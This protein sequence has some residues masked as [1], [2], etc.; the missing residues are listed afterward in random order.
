[1]RTELTYDHL[2]AVRSYLPELDRAL[3]PSNGRRRHW[4]QRELS[5]EQR[6]RMN[7]QAVAER[8]AKE[9]NLGLGLKALGNAPA[10]LDLSALDARDLIVTS[11]AELEEAVCDKLG[12]TP[13]ARPTTAERITRLIGLLDRIALHED[14]ADHVHAEA[15]RLRQ[16]ARIV[17]GE[18]EPVVRLTARCIHCR[19]LSLRA[20]PERAVIAARNAFAPLTN[21]E[22]FGVLASQVHY[23][24][25]AAT[26]TILGR[27]VHVIGANDAKAEPKV[28]G[29]TCAGA[30]VDEASTLPKDFFDQLN[31]RC[32]V[33]GAKIFA[34]TNPD[35]P[36]H[37]LRKEYLL[38]PS[39]TSLRA[40]HFRLDDNIHLDPTYVETIKS[41]YTGL[42]YKR[43]V[44]GLW[45]QAEGAVYDCFDDDLHVVDI[46]PTITRWISLGIDYGTAA[47]FAGL[48]L[49][50]G[51]DRKLY[52]TREYRYES[53]KA[54]RQL[55]DVEYSERLRTWL[56]EVPIPGTTLKGVRPEYVVVDPSALSFRVQLHNDGLTTHLA[57]NDV[58][59]GI[60]NVASLLAT[61]RLFVQ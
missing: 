50:F 29:M 11:V 49:G 45:V 4:N 8:E 53:K 23:T 42:F 16:T 55:T 48:L 39:E 24:N 18:A 33:F 10:P 26:A 7:A 34:T 1:M 13:L 51:V 17:L 57:N 27:T 43:S 19:S 15:A 60:R 12:L 30:Y 35:N 58:L 38:R 56:T 28:R 40:W 32:S 52:L 3:V 2:A 9:R 41:T 47:P 44:L 21:P 46:L 25:G 20:Y 31:A 22:L 5:S 6:A 36:G 37:W 59:D 61:R 54:H 14:L